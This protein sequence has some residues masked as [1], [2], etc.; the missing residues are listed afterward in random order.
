MGR[1]FWS[2]GAAILSYARNIIV[3][4]QNGLARLIDAALR[5]RQLET[6]AEVRATRALNRRVEATTVSET[7]AAS[8]GNE[9]RL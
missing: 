7:V 5:R 6:M 3:A 4:G 9:P 2:N 1:F 8:T